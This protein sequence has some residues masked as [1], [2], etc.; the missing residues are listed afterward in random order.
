MLSHY[1]PNCNASEGEGWYFSR[2]Y[3]DP[4]DGQIEP[5]YGQCRHCGF[6]YHQHCKHPLSQQLKEFQDKKEEK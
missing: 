1:C 5:D 3:C 4:D 6:Q 2:S